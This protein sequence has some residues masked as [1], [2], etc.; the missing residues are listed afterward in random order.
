MT[1][2][3]YTGAAA[4]TTLSA[5]IGSAD[6]VATLATT[7]N[8]PTS[9]FIITVDQGLVG[10][11]KILVGTRSGVALSGMTRA[12]DG[13]T[14]AS[15]TAGAAVLHTLSAVDLDEANAHVNSGPDTAPTDLHHT[16]GPGANQVSA[17]THGHIGGNPLTTLVSVDS[18]PITQH[19]TSTGTT[20][21]A[22]YA[23]ISASGAGTFAGLYKPNGTLPGK[24]YRGSNLDFTVRVYY[25]SAQLDTLYIG[26]GD[27]PGVS[28]ASAS[29][30]VFVTV[31]TATGAVGTL[32][33]TA[34]VSLTGSTT[35]AAWTQSS[36]T[37]DIRISTPYAGGTA[38]V[39]VDGVQVG[40]VATV[41]ALAVG[42]ISPFVGVATGATGFTSLYV[43][44]TVL[45]ET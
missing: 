9:N 26:F 13:T 44:Q 28:P 5:P 29:N 11:E 21:T 6:V 4:A 33:Q 23:V 17:G 41:P 38:T 40:T 18:P 42:A 16:I 36:S 20:Y 2:R 8:L 10:E 24:G 35:A 3:S 15:H 22:N 1:R 45:T 37:K 14:A 43:Y 7:A 39:T 12:F 30:G 19:W 34:S 31:N 25:T 27:T 32:R